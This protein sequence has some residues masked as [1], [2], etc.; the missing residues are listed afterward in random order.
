MRKIMLVLL[1]LLMLSACAG[2]PSRQV[3]NPP[4]DTRTPAGQRLSSDEVGQLKRRL[5]KRVMNANSH[6]I[7]FEAID[8]VRDKLPGVGEE[9]RTCGYSDCIIARSSYTQ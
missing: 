5:Q 1:G 3:Q 7:I 2:A 9:K 8:E 6:E 4:D